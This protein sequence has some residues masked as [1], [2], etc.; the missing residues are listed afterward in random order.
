MSILILSVFGQREE[1]KDDNL[2]P[3]IGTTL[4][5]KDVLLKIVNA[6]KTINGTAHIIEDIVKINFNIQ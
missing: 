5:V 6:A 2:C 4:C 3:L 1:K